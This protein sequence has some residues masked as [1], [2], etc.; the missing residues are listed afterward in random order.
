MC[1]HAPIKDADDSWVCRDLQP[2]ILFVFVT[3]IFSP[4]ASQTDRQ[5]NILLTVIY[6]DEKVVHQFSCTKVSCFSIWSKNTW[7]H[8][9]VRP[10]IK[11]KPSQQQIDAVFWQMFEF[12]RD[13][14]Y[15]KQAEIMLT[16]TVGH[17]TLCFSI[18]ET[19]FKIFLVGTVGKE[20]WRKQRE[21]KLWTSHDY[22]RLLR[23]QFD[24][25][26]SQFSEIQYLPPFSSSS[27]KIN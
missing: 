6:V 10:L 11:T 24:H 5:T 2:T 27:T 8:G 9:W 17:C 15:Q 12:H 25:C 13:H 18:H 16:R 20:E 21:D 23:L 14:G 4:P 19:V 26:S 1:M 22:F 7:S 3:N